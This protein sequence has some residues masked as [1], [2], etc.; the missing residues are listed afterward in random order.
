MLVLLIPILQFFF[1]LIFG[2]F[3]VVLDISLYLKILI[4]FVYPVFIGFFKSTA[5]KLADGRFETEELFEFYSF[6]LAALPFRYIYFSFDSWLAY[7]EHLGVKYIYKIFMHILVPYYSE[8]INLFKA[9]LKKSKAETGPDCIY[10]IPGQKEPGTYPEFIEKIQKNLSFHQFNDIFDTALLIFVMS[11]SYL[12][13]QGFAAMLS[14]DFYLTLLY[15]FSTDLVMELAFCVLAYSIIK[16]KYKIH[17]SPFNN[18]IGILR[19]YNVVLLS[20]LGLV[21]A[22]TFFIIHDFM[23]FNLYGVI[24]SS[25]D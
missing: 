3:F 18:F 24:A 10:Y 12:L 25:T 13:D 19:K 1:E 11:V 6:L 5:D 2:T 21:F 23:P 7:I 17:Y 16:R 14:E 8:S 22:E 20:M 9:K 15:Q 4:C